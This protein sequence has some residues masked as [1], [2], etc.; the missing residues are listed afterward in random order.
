[1]DKDI[2][3]SFLND[4]QDPGVIAEK[5]L[6]A[7]STYDTGLLGEIKAQVGICQERDSGRGRTPYSNSRRAKR[8][9]SC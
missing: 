5:I 2:C 1:M 9:L 3:L 7:T 6:T 8:K 4:L